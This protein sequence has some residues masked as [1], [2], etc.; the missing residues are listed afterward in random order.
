MKKRILNSLF[1]RVLV[2]FAMIQFVLILVFALALN[3]SRA[4]DVQQMKQVSIRVE[5]ISYDRSVSEY[6]FC[7]YSGTE[8][9]VFPNLGAFSEY[10]NRELYNE[11]SVGDS[12]SLEY[13][14]NIVF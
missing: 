3:E 1:Y 5:D 13:Y 10:S 2:G 7:I 12:I 6:R 11:I 4:I 9:Y 8:K 14:E